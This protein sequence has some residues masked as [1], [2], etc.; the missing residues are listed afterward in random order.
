MK[1]I[2]RERERERG[3]DREGERTREGER[4][5]QR[6]GGQEWGSR[7]FGNVNNGHKFDLNLTKFDFAYIHRYVCMY[8]CMYVYMFVGRLL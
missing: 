2:M 7:C 5:R 6:E 4:E 8:A 1:K 3:R